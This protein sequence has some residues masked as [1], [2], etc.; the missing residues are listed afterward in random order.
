MSPEI[1]ERNE[2]I[3]EAVQS[4]KTRAAVAREY[5]LTPVRICQIYRQMRHRINAPGATTLLCKKYPNINPE[6]VSR[7]VSAVAR[8]GRGIWGS[9]RKVVRNL[10]KFYEKLDKL[11][12]E[13]LWGIRGLGEKTWD[14][15]MQVKRDMKEEKNNE[16]DV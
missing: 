3:Y 14:F 1:L 16:K 13:D 5:G 2:K 6:V 12:G 9:D 11:T 4:G 7:G 8:E 15:L 10:N